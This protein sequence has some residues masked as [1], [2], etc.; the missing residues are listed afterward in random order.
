M[1]ACTLPSRT[2]LPRQDLSM[3]RYL[4]RV[5]HEAV[6]QYQAGANTM[7]NEYTDLDHLAA[8]WTDE[9]AAE[10]ERNLNAQ[11]SIDRALWP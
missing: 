6:G 5:L 1:N 4:V 7:A 9:D 11:R 3:N 10:F 8:T 2:R